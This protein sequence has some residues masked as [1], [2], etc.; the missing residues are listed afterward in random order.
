VVGWA[1]FE[2]QKRSKIELTDDYM[3]V[4]VL[5]HI[6]NDYFHLVFHYIPAS[7]SLRVRRGLISNWTFVMTNC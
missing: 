1:E 6:A 4:T 5:R 7:L 3:L 2:V